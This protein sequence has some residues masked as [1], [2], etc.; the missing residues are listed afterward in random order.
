MPHLD[1]PECQTSHKHN[2]TICNNSTQLRRI[3][4][5]AATPDKLFEGRPMYFA[6][7]EDTIVNA[8]KANTTV[9]NPNKNWTN[10]LDEFYW[11]R[12]NYTVI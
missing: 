10:Q 9:S 8:K 2:G 12:K 3:A 4:F 7:Y 1:V 6:L 5:H 11:D